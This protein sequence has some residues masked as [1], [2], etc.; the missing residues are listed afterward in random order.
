MTLASAIYDGTMR[1][2]RFVPFER[3]F[4]F[5]LF[6]IYLD[7]EE[8]PEVM[9][10]HPLWSTRR[11]SPVRFR[12]ADYLG[13]A[14]LPLRDAVCDL[15]ET[16]TG[17]RPVGPIRMLTHLRFWGVIQN[18]V[19]FYYCFDRQG[20]RLET[21]VAEVTNVPWG[22]RHAYV[23]DQQHGSAGAVSATMPKRLHVSPLMGMDHEYELNFGKP[24][25]SLPV[26]I[27][28]RH[29][30]RRY[31]DATLNLRRMNLSRSL[32][33]QLLVTRPPM[34]L[35]ATAGIYYQALCIWLRGARFHPK[36]AV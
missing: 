34:S 18:P 12:R 14:E 27:E 31:F 4:S 28:S 9:R 6:M 26:H 7:L 16:R 20:E 35:K 30:G 11:R 13:P 15:V 23:I 2:R 10:I 32:L 1:H 5:R 25:R 33:G 29:E 22:E 17:R 8:I 21:V 19:T 24:G 3:E 36:K